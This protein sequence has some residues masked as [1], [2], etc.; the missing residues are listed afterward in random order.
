M[1]SFPWELSKGELGCETSQNP[2]GQPQGDYCHRGPWR[3][4]RV[5][6]NPLVFVLERTKL[7]R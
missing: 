7:E 4:C 1:C 6:K 2:R 5:S 3:V